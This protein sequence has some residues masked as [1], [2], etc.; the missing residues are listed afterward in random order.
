MADAPNND[1]PGDEP[2]A[3]D[4]PTPEDA[5]E[6]FDFVELYATKNAI[7]VEMLVDVLHDHNIRCFVRNMETAQFPVSVG[8][9][10][11]LRIAVDNS[12]VEQARS[13]VEQTLAEGPGEEDEGRFLIDE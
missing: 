12:T 3:I 6:E 1:E 5:P 13:L 2:R 11:E 4:V 8:M 9:E 7:E 10:G